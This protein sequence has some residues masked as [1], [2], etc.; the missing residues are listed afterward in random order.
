M[1]DHV[2]SSID[3]YLLQ[4]KRRRAKYIASH[5]SGVPG[6]IVFDISILSEMIRSPASA[7]KLAQNELNTDDWFKANIV[8]QAI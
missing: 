1:A 5:E 4:V 3:K 2:K 8:K 7:K 6:L